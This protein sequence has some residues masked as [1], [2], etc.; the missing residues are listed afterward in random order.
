MIFFIR[1]ARQHDNK[2]LPPQ[3]NPLILALDKFLD[4]R[5]SNAGCVIQ[6]LKTQIPKISELQKEIAIIKLNQYPSDVSTPDF[7]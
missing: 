7:L 3:H 6:V 5:P 4:N 2:I 1:L